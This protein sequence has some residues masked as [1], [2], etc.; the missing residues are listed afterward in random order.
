MNL[1]LNN[2]FRFL[3]L[4]LFQVLV[5]NNIQLSGYINP[6]L[7]VLF[8]LLLPIEIPGWLLLILSFLTGFSV[9]I[10]TRSFGIHAAASLLMAYSRQFV[11]K[12]L[13]PR[14]GYEF[15][16]QPTLRDMGFKW[17]AYYAGILIFIH[18]AA[19]F[20]IETFRVSEFFYT[21]FR[22]LLSSVFTFVLV[23]ISQFLTYREKDAK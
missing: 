18:H 13:A 20:Y 5:L 14:E 16:I 1:I 8:I 11:L 12:I 10:F 9:D 7:Y 22:C 21:F 4:V 3:F 2:I 6:Y 23:V 17:V 15:G 19:L